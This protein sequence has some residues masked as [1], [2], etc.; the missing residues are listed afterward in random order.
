MGKV[1]PLPGQLGPANCWFH[2]PTSHPGTTVILRAQA[3]GLR[4][5]FTPYLQASVYPFVNV[6]L[7][8]SQA[9]CA[10]LG[11]LTRARWRSTGGEGPLVASYGAGL[12]G[13]AAEAWEAVG[14][15]PQAAAWGR[16]LPGA[17]TRVGAPASAPSYCWMI[18]PSS[19]GETE[20]RRG[21]RGE[22]SGGFIHPGTWSPIPTQVQRRTPTPTPRL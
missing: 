22:R 8:T 6:A 15:E 13:L 14:A 17:S 7:M 12:A 3:R 4:P 19:A 18:P 5:R 20:S 1:I 9:P 21:V 2:T 10:R 11:H 16:G